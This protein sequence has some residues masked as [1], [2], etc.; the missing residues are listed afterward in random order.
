[1]EGDRGDRHFCPTQSRIE[2]SKHAPSLRL[3]RPEGIKFQALFASFI[4]R[5]LDKKLFKLAIQL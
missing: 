2:K 5:F 1:V 4:T 3:L